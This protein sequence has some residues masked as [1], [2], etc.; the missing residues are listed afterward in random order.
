MDV[1]YR[2]Q[3]RSRIAFG[4]VRRPQFS[5]QSHAICAGAL[6]GKL[7]AL[8]PIISLVGMGMRGEV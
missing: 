4:H 7:A 3:A 6:E 1:L 8:Q 5:D 2:E